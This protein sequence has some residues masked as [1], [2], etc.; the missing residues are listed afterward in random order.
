MENI[1]LE[2]LAQEIKNNNKVALAM[3]TEVTGSSPAQE[4]AI[5]VILEDGEIL[6]TIGGG[7]FE[8]GAIEKAKQCMAEGKSG[9]FTFEVNNR[10]VD[11]SPHVACGG[12]AKVYIRVFIPKNKLILIGGGHVSFQVYKLGKLLGFYT[13]VFD[14]R[15]QFANK[16]RFPDADEIIFGEV[17]ENLKN[18]PIDDN[19]YIVLVSRGH[20]HDEIALKVVTNS[21]AKYIGMIG[22]KNKTE[23]ILK[24]LRNDGFSE[25]AI[26][27]LYS[28]IGINLGGTTPTEIAFSILA[29]ILLVKNN[30]QLV[31]MK[32]IK[33]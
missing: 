24:N 8:A 28:P 1:L 19:T 5:A 25:E 26:D 30:G 23:T 7:S 33:R 31:H 20:I 10:G 14:D 32:D 9:N 18:H 6:G 21:R 13:V 11:E 29:E 15:E 27:K 16:D 2:R 22:S 12:R 17:A 4:G 3:V